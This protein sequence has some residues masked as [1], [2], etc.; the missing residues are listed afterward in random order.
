MVT[1]TVIRTDVGTVLKIEPKVQYSG[2]P[3]FTWTKDGQPLPANVQVLGYV[4]YVPHVTKENQG[5]YTLTLIDDY[6]TAKIQ[7]TIIVDDR[8]SVAPAPVNPNRI[9]V[10]HDMDVELDPGQSANLVCQILP[11]TYN[12][13]IITTTSWVKGMREQRERFPSNIRPNQERLQIVKIKPSDAGMYT[14]VT[15][16]SDGSSQTAVVNIRVRDGPGGSGE[17]PQR[18]ASQPP[19]AQLDTREKSVQVG[20]T[21]ELTCTVGG[22][23]TPRVQWF[24]NNQ[25]IENVLGEQIAVRAVPGRY[26]LTVRDARADLNGYI[27]CR[28]TNVADGQAAEDAAV[29]RALP[30]EDTGPENT[31][32][33]GDIRVYVEPREVRARV[34]ETARLMCQA[35]DPRATQLRYLFF[36]LL[37]QYTINGII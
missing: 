28:A 4:L 15:I 34:G 25:P 26:T 19:S 3:Q 21:F 33:S 9:I 16:S 5:V 6:G 31:G 29:V 36:N 13:R 32:S 2:R 23:P 7:V 11:R 14:C 8:I 22:S 20:D 27:V 1:E 12:P 30:R 17:Q 18:P 10:K 24:Y 35:Q 37:L